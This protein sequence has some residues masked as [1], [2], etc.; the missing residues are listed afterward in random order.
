VSSKECIICSSHDQESCG[1]RAN[2]ARYIEILGSAH[3]RAVLSKK[4]KSSNENLIDGVAC[5]DKII[6]AFQKPIEMSEI[7]DRANQY[8]YSH[9]K[10]IL[11]GG[12]WHLQVSDGDSTF[13]FDLFGYPN[14]ISSSVITNPSKFQSF[15]EY[16]AMMTNLVGESAHAATLK[17]IDFAV[18]YPIELN[19]LLDGFDSKY[20]SLAAEFDEKSGE[21]T[22]LRIGK[23]NEVICV[24]DKAK[25][26]KLSETLTR[27]EVRLTKSKVKGKTLKDVYDLTMNENGFSNVVLHDL[28]FPL[29]DISL[30]P[31]QKRR[32]QELVTLIQNGGYWRT[33]KRLN[34]HGNF[35]RD[36][37]RL[38]CL[39]PWKNQPKEILMRELESFFESSIDK[40]K[41]VS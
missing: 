25:R 10:K 38:F 40:I 6:L 7:V 21:N 24:Y 27:V 41:K 11:R 26:E 17:R 37:G 2:I 39:T 12:K 32:K 35:K 9:K 36:Y 23:S 30:T 3:S 5:I 20:K 29:E 1:C 19:D 31:T 4:V 33:K 22:G 28:T 13:Y 16:L 8:G 14:D 15:E 18:D 34:K